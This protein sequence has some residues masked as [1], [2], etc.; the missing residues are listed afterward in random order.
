MSAS[1]QS[2]PS[3]PSFESAANRVFHLPELVG[4]ILGSLAQAEIARASSVTPT[5]R[6]EGARMLLRSPFVGWFGPTRG[7]LGRATAGLVGLV[8]QLER[9]PGEVRSFSLYTNPGSFPA[10]TLLFRLVSVGSNLT[11]VRI[12]GKL[13]LQAGPIAAG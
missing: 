6:D 12:D 2:A 1:T 11:E 10:G 4:I 13:I 3:R 7:L 5:F 8:E 9:R